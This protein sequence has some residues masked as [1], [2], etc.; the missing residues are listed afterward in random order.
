MATVIEIPESLAQE[1]DQLA[2]S[3]H[4]QRTAYVVDILWR[5][6]KR[7]KQRQALKLSSGAWN[8]TDHPELADGAAAY[9]ERMRSEPDV[10]FEDAIRRNPHP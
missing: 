8:P 7:S 6:V 5:D 1:L 4:K 10:R 9:I 3:E 2:E